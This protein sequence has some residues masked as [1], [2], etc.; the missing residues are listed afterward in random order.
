M[1]L[2][3]W[4]DESRIIPESQRTWAEAKNTI[5]PVEKFLQRLKNFQVAKVMSNFISISKVQIFNNF[6][7]TSQVRAIID[8]L[9]STLMN[10]SKSDS[11]ESLIRQI[12]MKSAAAGGIYTW[13]DSNIYMLIHND[14]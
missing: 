3:K 5:G 14:C 8:K 9:N 1:V 7:V 6:K 4:V 2:F 12:A 11:T 10:I 13:L